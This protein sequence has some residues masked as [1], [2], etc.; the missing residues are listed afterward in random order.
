MQEHKDRKDLK[1]DEI[2][3][4]FLFHLSSCLFSLFPEI[5][6]IHFSACKERSAY[7]HQPPGRRP[8]LSSSKFRPLA[9]RQKFV[10]SIPLHPRMLKR[11]TRLFH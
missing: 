7:G 6:S 11:V 2:I 9:C 8:L 4:Q 10:T 5:L 3:G 1:P